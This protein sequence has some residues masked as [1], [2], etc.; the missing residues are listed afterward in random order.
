METK[1]DSDLRLSYVHLAKQPA[2]DKSVTLIVSFTMV[3]PPHW[4]RKGTFGQGEEGSSLFDSPGGWSL[5]VQIP[6]VQVV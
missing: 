6:K 4:H 1:D 2:Q 5:T 3:V